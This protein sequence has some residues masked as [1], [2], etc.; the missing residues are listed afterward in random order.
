MKN[1]VDAGGCLSVG[2]TWECC[3]GL[4]AREVRKDVVGGWK[5]V[6]SPEGHSCHKLRL[7][8]ILYRTLPLRNGIRLSKM[9]CP[10]TFKEIKHMSRISYASMIGSF[11]YVMLCTRPDIA[12]VV[13]ITIGISQI[14]ISSTG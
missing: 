8:G 14:Q 7:G 13:S 4:A 2:K 11:I 12:L 1:P 6:G 5:S 3:G 9:M 10:N